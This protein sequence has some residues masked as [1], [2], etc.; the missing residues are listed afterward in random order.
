[1][2]PYSKQLGKTN[3]IQN[4]GNGDLKQQFIDQLQNE[5][6]KLKA[7]VNTLELY[8]QKKD[9]EC[10]SLKQQLAYFSQSGSA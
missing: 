4:A 5:L 1:M 9:K 8:K 3:F 10:D 7:T 2:E 6:K